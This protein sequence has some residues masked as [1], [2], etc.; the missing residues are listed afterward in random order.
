MPE[1]NFPPPPPTFLL[2]TYFLIISSIYVASCLTRDSIPCVLPP[3]TFLMFT[4]NT[5]CLLF[6][7]LATLQTLHVLN[8]NAPLCRILFPHFHGIRSR[9]RD[10]SQALELNP[11]IFWYMTGETPET[12]EVV[13]ET[14]YQEV[15]APR[16]ASNAG[17]EQETPL[18]S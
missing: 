17:N 6:T 4:L 5:F 3:P 18:H 1:E 12:L 2:L 10:I 9:G 11:V 16:L 14:I 15:T 13:V 7:A 8:R